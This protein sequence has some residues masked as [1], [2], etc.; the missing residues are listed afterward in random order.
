MVSLNR[1]TV[2]PKSHQNK[3]RGCEV[4]DNTHIMSTLGLGR[5]NP[6]EPALRA[7]VALTA[8]AA[9]ACSGP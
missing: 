9:G 8:A 3:S 1:K 4:N 7:A 5:R 2:L 6:P